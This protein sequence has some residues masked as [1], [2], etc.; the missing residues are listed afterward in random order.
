MSPA[1]TVSREQSVTRIAPIVSYPP[2]DLLGLAKE[3][4][5]DWQLPA[6][7]DGTR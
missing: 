7:S 6:D 5:V 1:S 2:V 3:M 4:V